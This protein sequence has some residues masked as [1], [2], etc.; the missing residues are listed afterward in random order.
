MKLYIS[1][2][3]LLLYP[4]Q[5]SKVVFKKHYIRIPNKSFE[6]ATICEYLVMTLTDKNYIHKEIQWRLNS[7]NACY[8][9]VYHL[10]SSFL[11]SKIV[12]INIRYRELQPCLL[13]VEACQGRGKYLGLIHKLGTTAHEASTFLPTAVLHYSPS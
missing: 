3:H 4:S 12:Y 8:H 2:Y 10:L 9:L 7:R 13:V 1:Q 11:L 5:I 6:N